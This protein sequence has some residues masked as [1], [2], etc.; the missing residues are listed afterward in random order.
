MKATA[1][2]HPIQPLAKDKSGVLRFKENKIVSDLLDL[3]SKHGLSLND[4]AYRDYSNEDRQQ[5]AQ[6]IGYSLCGYSELQSYVD[7]AA[8]AAAEAK[9]RG[10][11]KSDVEIERD[12]YR[13]ELRALKRA[14]QKP[15]ARLFEC[16]PNDLKT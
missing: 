11:K 13:A 5:L 4:I 1:Q 15:M 8:Y 9:S 10:S 14:L 3:A 2:S 7:D 12:Y 16:H 6:L